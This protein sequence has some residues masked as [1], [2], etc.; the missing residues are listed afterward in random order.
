MTLAAAQATDIFVLAAVAIG[1]VIGMAGLASF[2]PRLRG[3]LP[4]GALARG[5]A[6]TS[7]GLVIAGL[8]VVGIALGGAGG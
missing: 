8:L 6:A 4:V 5:G 3:R 2:D 1:A 7:I